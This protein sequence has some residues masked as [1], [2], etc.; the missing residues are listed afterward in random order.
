MVPAAF[1][2]L[3][4]SAILAGVAIALHYNVAKYKTLQPPR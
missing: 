3:A 2:L 4:S 1:V